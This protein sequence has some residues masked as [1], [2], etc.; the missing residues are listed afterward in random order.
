[1]TTDNPLTLPRSGD[2]W[3]AALARPGVVL[4]PLRLF[5]GVTFT[6]AGLQKL[7]D[8]HFFDASR[9]QSIQGQIML[10]RTTS[11][12]KFLLGP[13]SHHAVAFGVLTAI[14]EIGVGIGTL[15]GLW[16]RAAAALGAFLSLSFYLT[17]SWKTR[18]YYYG[19]D[20][21]FV[22]M[23]VPF[24]LAG[25]GGVLSLDAWRTKRLVARP[26]RGNR[27]PLPPVPEPLFGRRAVVAT[28]AVAAGGLALAGLDAAIGRGF[29]NDTSS[30]GANAFPTLPAA[31]TTGPAGSSSPAASSAPAPATSG[32]SSPTRSPTSTP[33][34]GP[35]ITTAAAVTAAGGVG[36]TDPST[37]DPAYVV[38]TAAG[39]YKA[40]SAICTHAGCTVAFLKKTSQF[41][42]P[43]HG[44]LYDAKTG[45]VLS[46]PPPQ[47]LPSIAVKNV[48]GEIKL[49]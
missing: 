3:R 41:Q 12:I 10:F 20:I 31:A 17:V 48:N 21:V 6:F 45:Q 30:A 43:C 46:G 42:C 11:P 4:L 18:P 22:F 25:S 37:G 14:A 16:S 26:V 24:I 49:G 15:V 5:L 36:F 33:A 9:P 32:T 34:G 29:A 7:A 19:S 38:Q 8:P 47:P 2:E 40:F 1:M 23:W 28:G 39:D 44:G 27:R 13:I 35:T